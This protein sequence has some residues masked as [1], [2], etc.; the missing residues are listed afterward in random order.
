MIKYV[1]EVDIRDKKVLLRVDY[2][3][4]LL[5]DLA[6]ANSERIRRSLSTINLLLQKKN[7]LILLSHL[8]RPKERE[9]K[10]SLRPV[11]QKLQSLLPSYKVVLINDFESAEGKKRIENQ[12][13]SE[14]LLLENMRFYSGEKN[15]EETFAKQLASHG[16]VYVNDAFGVSHRK[17][18]SITI[19][20]QL[21]PSYGGLL[22]KKEVS[23][24]SKC[25]ENP[26][27]PF[28]AVIGGAKISTKIPLLSKLLGLADALLLGGGI[29]NTLLKEQG[30]EIGKS[31]LEEARLSDAKKLIELSKQ[32]NALLLL[33]V[34]VIVAKNISDRHGFVKKISEI[35]PDDMILDIGPA[36]MMLFGKNIIQAKTIVWNGPLGYFENPEFRRGTDFVYYSIAQNQNA[37]SIVGGGETLAAISKKEYLDKITHVSTGGGAMLQ[38]IEKDTLPGLEVLSSD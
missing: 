16:D 30:Y 13:N 34:D 31:L 32:K 8:G 35:A 6:I 24:I 36:T 18:A 14:V 33:P 10:Y 20:P 38:F 11:A 7:K 25:I 23:M 19:L 2:N 1:D 27:K 5:P 17:N 37:V 15:N 12:K 3:V 29:A 26:K 21:I 9:E 4:T 28:V 22:L